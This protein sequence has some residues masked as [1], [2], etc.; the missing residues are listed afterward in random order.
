[1]IVNVRSAHRLVSF[2]Q[3]LKSFYTLT[4]KPELNTLSHLNTEA[5]SN[6]NNFYKGVSIFLS[7]N[8]G[9]QLFFENLDILNKEKAVLDFSHKSDSIL[10]RRNAINKLLRV[11][12]IKKLIFSKKNVLKKNSLQTLGL[13]KNF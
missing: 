6:S 11:N 12:F 5:M 3:W 1:M 8:F 10:Y 4:K 7:K 13:N 2:F 9:S